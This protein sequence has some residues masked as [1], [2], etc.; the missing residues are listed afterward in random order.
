MGLEGRTALVT[1]AA[2]GIGQG[3]ALYLA[4][5]GARVAVNYRTAGPAL[6][7]TMAALAGAGFP[8]V[9]VRADVRYRDQVRAMVQEVIT[10][11]GSLDILVNNAG[12]GLWGSLVDLS[13]DEWD[14]MIDT[15]LKGAYLCAQAAAP[16][17]IERGWGRIVNISSTCSI[18]II[19]GMG[20]YCTSKAALA[21]LT[22][23]LAVDLGRFGITANA[24][25]P[26]TVPTA[27]NAA[28][29]AR[30][31]FLEAEQQANPSGRIGTVNDI[32]AAVA[33]LASDEAS[34]INGQNLIVD[35]GLTTLSPQ[36]E[37]T[38]ET[39]QA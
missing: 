31:G 23:G 1:G 27:M 30:P 13:E 4:Q 21:M 38:A 17:M 36:P 16:G 33:F 28:D 34:W 24:V 14:L 3:I 37:Y 6:D 32:A 15:N 35:G 8:G 18:R 25:G 12:V 11:L 9:A 39:G 22:K 29:L 10:H 2:T 20:A 19:R 5:Q 26:S 7:E